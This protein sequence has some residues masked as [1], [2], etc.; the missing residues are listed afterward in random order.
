MDFGLTADQMLLAESARDFLAAEST[1]QTVRKIAGDEHGFSPELFKKIV[2]QGWTGLLVPEAYGGLGL[3]ML[4][5]A[6]LLTELGRT[7]TP[8]PILSS[9]S[10]VLWPRRTRSTPSC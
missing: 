8:A 2:A 3:G 9:H 10:A 6:V 4:D 5:A 1:P 7:L